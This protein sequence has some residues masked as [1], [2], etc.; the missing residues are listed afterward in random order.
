MKISSV[1]IRH[2]ANITKRKSMSCKHTTVSYL[3]LL[4]LPTTY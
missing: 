2:R 4:M 1:G 3:I